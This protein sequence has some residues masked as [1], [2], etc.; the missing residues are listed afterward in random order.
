MSEREFERFEQWAASEGRSIKWSNPDYAPRP[1]VSAATNN[2]LDG[3]QAAL[4]TRRSYGFGI[5]GSDG[6][7][8]D[9]C[10]ME[11][12]AALAREC[13]HYHPDSAPHR[14]VVLF[15]EDQS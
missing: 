6:S 13:D 3:W 7:N 14:V 11:N 1:Y 9:Y 12:A 10:V 4:S 2:A 5:V 15:Y 8:G